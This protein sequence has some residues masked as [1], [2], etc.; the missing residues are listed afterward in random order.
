MS[1]GYAKSTKKDLLEGFR[2][3]DENIYK[4]KI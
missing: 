4:C 1:S 3:E 2:F